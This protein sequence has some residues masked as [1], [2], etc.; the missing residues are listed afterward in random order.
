MENVIKIASLVI[1]F[2][3]IG[4]VVTYGIFV[5][6]KRKSFNR[7]L[8]VGD[9]VN[10]Y[11]AGERTTCKVVSL[12]NIYCIV[13]DELGDEARVERTDIYPNLSTKY[14]PKVFIE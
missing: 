13:E 5:N 4:V 11:F 12:G 9:V 1:I 3:I 2:G 10:C 8:K 7:Y 6:Q 14:E